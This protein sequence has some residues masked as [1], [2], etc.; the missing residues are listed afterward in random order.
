LSTP[1][2]TPELES[3]QRDSDVDDS[4]SFPVTE[5]KFA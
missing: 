4:G 3:H 2:R 5:T 1:K